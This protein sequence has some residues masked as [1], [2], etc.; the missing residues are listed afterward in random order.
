MIGLRS[1][2]FTS[3]LPLVVLSREGKRVLIL[4]S[5]VMPLFKW[6]KKWWKICFKFFVKKP[7]SSSDQPLLG[8][9]DLVF[10]GGYTYPS[11]F[12]PPSKKGIPP[13]ITFSLLPLFI[14][15]YSFFL[16]CSFNEWIIVWNFL[17]IIY[18]F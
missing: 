3:Q 1:V 6:F 17:S 9:L 12:L 18:C 14:L 4:N 16:I 5:S 10:L 11:P 7:T 15:L 2:E 8:K 13:P